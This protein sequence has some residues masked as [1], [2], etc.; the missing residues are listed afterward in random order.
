MSRLRGV[1]RLVAELPRRG[2]YADRLNE[3]QVDD[4]LLLAEPECMFAWATELVSASDDNRIGQGVDSKFQWDPAGK[5]IY[6]ER[7]VRAARNVWR[8]DLEPATLR[9]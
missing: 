1:V 9:A 7:T 6:F 8:I 3:A 2:L 5:G 4:V